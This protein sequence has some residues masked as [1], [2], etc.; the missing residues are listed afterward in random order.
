MLPLLPVEGV[1]ECVALGLG[2]LSHYLLLQ[3]VDHRDIKRCIL[4]MGLMG[5]KD[6]CWFCL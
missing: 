2:S 4:P 1:A 3:G 6:I 5:D